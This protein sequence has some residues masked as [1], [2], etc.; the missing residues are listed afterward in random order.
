MIQYL[1][2]HEMQTYLFAQFYCYF[3]K[4]KMWLSIAI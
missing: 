3:F 2:L 1:A 4:K